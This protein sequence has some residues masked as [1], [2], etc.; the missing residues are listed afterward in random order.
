MIKK[1]LI[2]IISFN[3]ISHCGFTPLYS[4]KSDV[5]F[6]ITSIEFKGDKEINNYLKN[7]LNKFTNNESEKKYTIKINSNYSKSVLSKNKAA[8]TTNFELSTDTTFQILSNSKILKEFKISEKKIMDN[9][10]DDF[11]EQKNEK[12]AKQNFASSMTI[13]L[14]TE[15]SILND[16]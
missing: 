6:S 1:F 5:I 9:I 13:K 12:I 7:S 2:L 16:N 4:N 8:E 3:L 11:E 15:I 14:V 10:D